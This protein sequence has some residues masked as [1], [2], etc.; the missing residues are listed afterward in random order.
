MGYYRN[1]FGTG[2][3]ASSAHTSTSTITKQPLATNVLA[4][5][6]YSLRDLNWLLTVSVILFREAVLNNWCIVVN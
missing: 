5:N 2:N 4:V 1:V 6:V 3:G